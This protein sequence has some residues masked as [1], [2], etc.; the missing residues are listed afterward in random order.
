[1]G[2]EI[3][4]DQIIMSTRPTVSVFHHKN[5]KEVLSEVRMPHVFLA[6]VRNDVVSFVHDQLAK[7]T[8]Q[9]HGVD[10]KAGM[11]H[12]AESWGT[13]R[14]V[15]RIPRVSGSGTHRSGQAA[16]GNMCRKGRMAHPL[17]TWRRWHRKVNLNQRRHALASAIAATACAPLVLARGHR[18]M[19]VNQLPLVLEDT[20]GQVAKTKDAIATLKALG[21]WD[22]VMRVANNRQLRAGKGKLRG[23]RMK[24]RRGPLFVVDE[25]CESLRRAVRNIQGVD[26]MNV[27]R[28]NVR[29][30]APGGHLGRLCVWTQSAF[31]ALERH[32]GSGKGVS[33]TK[34]GYRLQNEVVTS[35]DLSGIVNSDAVQS[36]LRDQKQQARRSRGTKANPLVNKRAMARLNPYSTVLREMRKK[37]AGVKRKIT[38][39]E[40]KD[41]SKRSN[42]SRAR[43]QKLLGSVNQLAD[44]YTETY[45]EQV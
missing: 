2:K 17:Q 44:D 37:Q 26:V 14:A 23:R 15:A 30:L 20:V 22:D 18:V 6:P 25:G 19:N 40:R 32:F 31:N 3:E 28:L 11:K 9:A 42:V 13:G 8:R 33:S 1:M 34:K 7:N 24:M 29:S 39:Q 43:M 10:K 36:V 5:E 41:K 4:L 35:A 21:L 12:S 45:R 38:K 16:F 27:N